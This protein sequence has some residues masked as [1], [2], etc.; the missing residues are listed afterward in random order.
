MKRLFSFAFISVATVVAFATVGCATLTDDAPEDSD[1]D[2]AESEVFTRNCPTSFTVTVSNVQAS[3][4]PNDL[5]DQHRAALLTIQAEFVAAGTITV[6]GE[7]AE[8]KSGVCWYRDPSA[9]APLRPRIKFYS[10]G[11]KDILELDADVDRDPYTHR[12]RI[13]AL[14]SAYD[15]DGFMFGS[16]GVLLDGVLSIPDGPNLVAKVGTGTIGTMK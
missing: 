8:R 4:L 12:H 9:P 5:S 13:Y 6:T 10:K 7:L 2:D 16:E 3:P 14:P 15:E 1:L 11:G